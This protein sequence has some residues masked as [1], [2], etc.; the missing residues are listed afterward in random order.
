MA[1]T[2][3]C[4][5]SK[6]C[7]V[8][9]S[10]ADSYF[11]MCK[12]SDYM[13]LPFAVATTNL[14][15]ELNLCKQQP[16]YVISV[17]TGQVVSMTQRW[18]FIHDDAHYRI[19]TVLDPRYK[20]KWTINSDEAAKVSDLL[21]AHYQCVGHLQTTTLTPVLIMRMEMKEMWAVMWICTVFW[22]KFC[23]VVL[24]NLTLI[25]TTPF[26]SDGKV[27]KFCNEQKTRMWANAQRDGHP[28]EHRWCPLFNAAKSGWRPLLDAVQQCCQDA[29]PVEIC[30]GAPNYWIKLSC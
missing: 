25:V 23:H 11:Y 4:K 19:S 18:Q 12:W 9:N 15:T 6:V 17:K 27:T 13:H 16:R 14:E 20:L 22:M 3:N 21:I 10:F 29:K 1:S 26:P 28:A 24:M 2:A 7:E 30:R 5:M 8:H